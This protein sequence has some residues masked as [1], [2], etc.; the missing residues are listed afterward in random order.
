M[1]VT[2]E[3]NVLSRRG[4]VGLSSVANRPTDLDRPRWVHE[5]LRLVRRSGTLPVTAPVTGHVGTGEE[6]GNYTCTV[7]VRLTVV[8]PACSSTIRTHSSSA[9]QKCC[10]LQTLTLTPGATN[11]DLPG[12][13]PLLA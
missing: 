11:H 9:N 10:R 2:G 1:C 5:G 4:A 13:S 6:F 8:V 7:R 12:P 3:H